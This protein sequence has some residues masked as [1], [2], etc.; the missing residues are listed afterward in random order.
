M[1]Q[2]SFMPDLHMKGETGMPSRL[3][4]AIVDR[5]AGED[6]QALTEYGLVLALIALAALLA[7]TAIGLAIASELETF[8]GAFGA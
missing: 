6:G 3:Y 4:V 1:K 2:S 5:I 7:L 8:V